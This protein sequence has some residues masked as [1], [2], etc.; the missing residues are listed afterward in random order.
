[1]GPESRHPTSQSSLTGRGTSVS[2]RLMLLIARRVPDMLTETLLF[3]VD[4][5]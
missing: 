1:M 3:V 2:R 5:L 4:F